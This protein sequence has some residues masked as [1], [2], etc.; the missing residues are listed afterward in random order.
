[1]QANPLRDS[2]VCKHTVLPCNEFPYALLRKAKSLFYPFG[3]NGFIATIQTIRFRVVFFAFCLKSGGQV[4]VERVLAFLF[5]WGRGEWRL[6]R[7]GRIWNEILSRYALQNDKRGA[8]PDIKAIWI[9][10]LFFPTVSL[11]RSVL[12]DCGNLVL[13][14]ALSLWNVAKR[15]D[16]V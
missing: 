11:R 5:C 6:K 4:C 12:C 13:I 16:R 1:M 3:Y 10:T 8:W 15:N 9:S 14:F 2:P 7:R